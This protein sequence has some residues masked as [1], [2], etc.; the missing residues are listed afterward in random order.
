MKWLALLASSVLLVACN[1]QGPLER[2]G[3]NVDNAVKDL[4]SDGKA[5]GNKVGDAADDVKDAAK[6][7][8]DDLK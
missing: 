1:E 6:D 4:K 5:V 2:A 7:A 3:E 8:A